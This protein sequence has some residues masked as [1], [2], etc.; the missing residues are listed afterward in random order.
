MTFNSRLQTNNNI[1]LLSCI[2]CRF[3]KFGPDFL[4]FLVRLHLL[5]RSMY[6]A[7]VVA[8][9]TPQLVETLGVVTGAVIFTDALTDRLTSSFTNS[10]LFIFLSLAHHPS[11]SSS[12]STS[13]SASILCLC[14]CLQGSPTSCWPCCPCIWSTPATCRSSS[15]RC[16]KS[17]T[18]VP[19]PVL[20]CLVLSCL[21][22]SCHVMSCSVLSS[23][24][25]S[26]HVM[27]CLVPTSH[28][29]MPSRNETQTN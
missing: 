24:V 20:S 22:L 2:C 23:H 4:V 26:C 15:P 7:L 14:L 17:P 11:S 29:S 27:S 19:G 18:Q 12:A 6:I 1:L 5:L 25:L 3:G 28:L 9:F 21:V 8:I 10:P 13:S 16:A